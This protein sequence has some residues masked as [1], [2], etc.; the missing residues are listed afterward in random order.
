M[1][2]FDDETNKV[3]TLNAAYKK[4]S[5]NLKKNSFNAE[6]ML[7]TID[8]AI[9]LPQNRRFHE[10]RLK[11]QLSQFHY[12]LALTYFLGGKVERARDHWRKWEYG[13]NKSEFQLKKTYSIDL[14]LCND[15]FFSH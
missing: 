6:A 11:E 3:E 4:H 2:L 14:G 8:N 12:C 7:N 13:S 5:K 15:F 10:A 1:P 9:N